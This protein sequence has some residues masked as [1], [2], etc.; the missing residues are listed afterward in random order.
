MIKKLLKKAS[1]IEPHE[2]KATTLSFLLVF[3]LMLAYYILR[4]V[5]D[6]MASDWTDAEV[7]QLW[8]LN[9]FISTGVVALYGLA[10]SKIK[11]KSLV[12]GVYAFFAISF[13]LFY[14]FMSTITDRV[15]IEKSFYI[16]I[17]VFGMFH[18]S[19]FWSFMS[20]LF[21]KDQA[22]RLF[23]T[24]ATG[25]SAGALIGP[26]IPTIFAGISG[27]DNL[28][29]V[30]SVLLLFAI[31]II[32]YLSKIKVEVFKNEDTTT[33]M[34]KYKIG[35][36]PF[37]GFKSFVTNPYL[38]AIGV[39][40]LLYTMISTFVYFEQ[41]NLLAEYDRATRTQIL[42]SIDWIV[43]VLTFG[44]AF[45]AT[46]RIVKNI[47]M[48]YTL[49]IMPLIVCAGILV[50][51]FAPIIVV[52]LALQVGRRAGNYAITKPARE[53]LF[54]EVDKETRFKAKPVIDV[55]VYRGGDTVTAWIFTGLTE[56]LGLGFAAV[57]V[58]GAGIAA[59]WA[60]VGIY[61]GKLY[62]R[63]KTKE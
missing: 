30:A 32:V 52:L 47:G 39:F 42:G 56:G 28:V 12:P 23:A 54:T 7:S 27:T 29:L 31:P 53:M 55:V 46:S 21:N 10:V 57:G 8:T 38:L 50:L 62:N 26:M 40:I 34:G 59:I 9:F 16:W 44:I 17:S 3:V 14:F 25:A 33:D 6:A 48:G 63:K 5:R 37:A 2:I 41:K 24:I 13:V 11:F 1:E 49:A 60:G 18:L 61:M 19:V 20:D 4:P 43:N 35:G 51:A 36:N 15:L 45:F 22:R 58:I